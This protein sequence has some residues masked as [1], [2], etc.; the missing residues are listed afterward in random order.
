MVT[1]AHVETAATANLGPSRSP[2]SLRKVD[3]AVGVVAHVT[4]ATASG[5]WEDG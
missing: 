3:A 4:H 5:P 2:S 1:I